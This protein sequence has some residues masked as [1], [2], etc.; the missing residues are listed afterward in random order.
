MVWKLNGNYIQPDP[1]LLMATILE[2]LPDLKYRSADGLRQL[3]QA[4]IELTI[5]MAE[6][7]RK[8]VCGTKRG[9]LTRYINSL[10][11]RKERVF[12][13]NQPEM[14]KIIYE[15]MLSAEGMGLLHG[16]GFGNKWGDYIAGNPEYH[17]IY[18]IEQ[19]MKGEVRTMAEELKRSELVAAAKELNELLGLDPAIDVKAKP[20]E[21][22]EKLLD[23]AGLL[24]E[25]DEVTKTTT[26]VLK[27]LK[28][29]GE[30]V[31]AEAAKA[32]AEAEGPAKG[33]G[34]PAIDLLAL[35]R[36]TK[37]LVELKAII[38]EYDVFKKLRK[39]LDAYQ[40]MRGPQELKPL[41]L[42]LLGGMKTPEPEPEAPAPK[43][44]AASGSGIAR[45]D[46]IG[47]LIGAGKYTRKQIIEKTL[48][49]FPEIKPSTV[50]T[51]LAD[52]KNEKYNSFPR[53]VKEDAKGIISF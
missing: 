5:D 12:P 8:E 48:E 25:G 21:L 47:K 43:K 11:E 38:L 14:L 22:K 46:Y 34:A 7:M 6:E 27:A 52:G 42:K 40:G 4:S 13:E 16:F 41:M 3:Y 23:A 9:T 36:G 1:R 29:Q 10:A 17:S 31:Q 15:A 53:I 44:R 24:E 39:G 51:A 37:K 35:V 19:P 26:A 33:A 18:N 28:P 2:A 30:D 45:R 20:A 50:A 32:E 49:A